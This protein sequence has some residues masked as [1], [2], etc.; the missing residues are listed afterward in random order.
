[1]DDVI[2]LIKDLIFGDEF[3]DESNG[4]LVGGCGPDNKNSDVITYGNL[5]ITSRF[6]N[7]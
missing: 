4:V 3:I 7:V 6:H 1:M 5:K 2:T